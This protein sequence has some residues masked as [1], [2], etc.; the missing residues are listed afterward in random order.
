ME[1]ENGNIVIFKT[2]KEKYLKTVLLQWGS[3]EKELVNGKL[4]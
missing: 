1:E 2:N 3:G 4:F